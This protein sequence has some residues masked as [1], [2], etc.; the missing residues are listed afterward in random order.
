MPLERDISIAING[1]FWVEVENP[2]HLFAA[3]LISR[4][5]GLIEAI[6][7]MRQVPLERDINSAINGPVWV[8]VAT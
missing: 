8:E 2:E 7:L 5:R 1:P 3:M 4:S 6:T